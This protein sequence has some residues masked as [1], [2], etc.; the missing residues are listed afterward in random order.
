LISRKWP[1]L[2][3]LCVVLLE[4]CASGTLGFPHIT[5]IDQTLVASGLFRGQI[6]ALLE[7][8]LQLI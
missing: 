8:R 7:L 4:E 6:T 1:K 2:L 5:S 3:K